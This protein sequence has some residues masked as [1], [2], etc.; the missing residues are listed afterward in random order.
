[1]DI[2][3]FL[4]G[5]RLFQCFSDDELARFADDGRVVMVRT[6]KDQ[7]IALQG[8]A[9]T[10]LDIVLDG[11]LS[12]QSI[13]EQGTV[14][15]A[16]VLEAGDVWGATLLFSRYNCYPM[17]VVSDQDG[18]LL[19][20]KKQVVLE[21]CSCKR[22]FLTDL[23]QIISDR[24]HELGLTVTKLNEQ[25][26]KQSLL[27]YLVQL[28]EKQCSSKIRLPISKTE[29]ANR[30]GCARTSLSRE[31]ALLQKEGMLTMSGRQVELHISSNT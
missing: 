1:M 13:D 5:V 30:I 21:L 26:L 14:F 10:T 25:T 28:S 19:R 8:D 6:T 4:R 16:R 31:F 11:R 27:A 20:L 29:L 3:R 22:E 18:S 7:L 9:C 23:L 2:V 15:K 17:Q 12:L 24:A